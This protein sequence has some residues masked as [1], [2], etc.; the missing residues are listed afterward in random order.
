[1]ATTAFERALDYAERIGDAEKTAIIRLDLGTIHLNRGD[2]VAAE[3]DYR[4]AVEQFRRMDHP[5]GIA[6]ALCNL[7]DTLRWAGRAGECDPI[8]DET[9]AALGAV[10]AAF[11]HAHLGVARAEQHLARGERD[12]ARAAAERA[13]TV[14]QG[15][16][17]ETGINLSRLTL[18]RV[19]ALQEQHES[20]EQVLREALLGFEGA[21]EAL[22]AARALVELSAVVARTGR[23]EEARGMH[24]DGVGRLRQLDAEPWSAHLPAE[25]CHG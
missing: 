15:A 6:A 20:A 17:Y 19:L 7:A 8:L 5:L 14:A 22:E 1:E 16:E 10:D 24:A 3:V 11:L 12:A 2:W 23:L 4:S 21:G 9:E 25:P 18:G 13:L